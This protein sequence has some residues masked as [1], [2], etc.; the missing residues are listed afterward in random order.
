LNSLL[1]KNSGLGLLRVASSFPEHHY[2]RCLYDGM[3]AG[4]PEVRAPLDILAPAPWPQMDIYHL[5]WPEWLGIGAAADV[6]PFLR[7]LRSR[8]IRIL[9]TQHNLRPHQPTPQHEGLYEG[10]AALVDGVIHHTSTG[11]ALAR[12][13]LPYRK[14]CFTRSSLTDFLAG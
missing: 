13:V 12:E 6:L 14:T 10:V 3:G 7:A 9:L 1:L 4:V 8:G 5:H 2:H 11:Q